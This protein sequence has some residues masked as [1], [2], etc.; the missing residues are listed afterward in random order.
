MSL[1]VGDLDRDGDLDV[2]VGEHN[3]KEP[4]SARLHVFENV[5]GKGAQW[6]DRVVHTGDEDDD[7][8]VVVDIDGDGDLDVISIGWSHGK[9]VLYENKAL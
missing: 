7:G 9:V 6:L 5:D 3:Y 8:A 4:A 2:V 1:D